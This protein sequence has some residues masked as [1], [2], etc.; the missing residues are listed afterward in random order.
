MVIKY[1]NGYKTDRFTT[2]TK[3]LFVPD[4]YRKALYLKL[5]GVTGS[6]GSLDTPKAGAL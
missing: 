6:I 2:S 3:S 4:I 1:Y 5:G